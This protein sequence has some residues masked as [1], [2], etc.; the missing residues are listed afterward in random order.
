MKYLL[1]GAL[2]L[3]FSGCANTSGG[4]WV[5]GNGMAE[6]GISEQGMQDLKVQT[7]EDQCVCQPTEASC[8][9]KPKKQK[10]AR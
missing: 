7:H 10:K 5:V 9:C 6:K 2:C 3:G 4:G 1:L 8:E